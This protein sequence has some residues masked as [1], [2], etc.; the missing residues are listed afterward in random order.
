[1]AVY[2]GFLYSEIPT[3]AGHLVSASM[4]SAPAA[5]VMSKLVMP[6]AGKPRT[7]GRVVEP[8]A[9]A[10]SSWVEAVINGSREGV[11]LVVGIVALLLAFLGL[12]AMVNWAIGLAGQWV[13]GYWGISPGLSL[14]KIFATFF[15]R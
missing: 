5:I 6:E 2:I 4:L 13:G 14:Q 12:L 11:K 9:A 3:I 15:I 10:F 1:M 8:R 7:L